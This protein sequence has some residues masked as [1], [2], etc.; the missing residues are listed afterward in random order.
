MIDKNVSNFVSHAEII[1]TIAYRNA[2]V[3]LDTS[4]YLLVAC[5][6]VIKG[7]LVA[8]ALLLMQKKKNFFSYAIPIVPQVQQAQELHRLRTM[9]LLQAAAPAQLCCSRTKLI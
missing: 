3:A 9:P 4:T 5:C 1:T 8:L 2:F 7:N 6:F